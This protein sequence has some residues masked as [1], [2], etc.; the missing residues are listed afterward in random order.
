MPNC[1]Q[2]KP[3]QIKQNIPSPQL[4]QSLNSRKRSSLRSNKKKCFERSNATEGIGQYADF[5][6]GNTVFNIH[7]LPL[8][9]LRC[10]NT[11]WACICHQKLVVSRAPR[12]ERGGHQEDRAKLFTVAHGGKT[13]HKLKQEKFR[14]SIRIFL[15]FPLRTIQGC[16]EVVQPLWRFSRLTWIKP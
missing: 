9:H 15:F 4:S 1:K 2:D 8:Y 10:Q 14:L 5:G 13:R 7:Y 3:I 6:R 11:I 12:S 16:T